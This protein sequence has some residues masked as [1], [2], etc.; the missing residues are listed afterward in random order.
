VTRR[1]D[2]CVV[3]GGL[4]G[5][6]VARALLAA[7]DGLSLLVLEKE[8][9]VGV[10]Q[11]GHNSGVVH[12]GLYYRPGSLKAK[13]CVTGRRELYDL[14]DAATLPVRRSGKVVVATD[15]A[16]LGALDELERRGLANGL[17]G[18]RR[19]DPSGLAELEPNAV[20]VAALHV[21]DTGVIDFPAV[22]I[23]LADLL[24]A[25]GAD[26]RTGHRVT[27]ITHTGDGVAVRAGAE[28]FSARVLVNC[29]GLHSDRIAEL[30]RVQPS[31]RIVP[32]RGEYYYLHPR[33]DD[34]VRNLIYPVPDPRF[35]F[36][37]VHFTRTVGGEVEVGPNAV[38]ALGRQHYHGE[39]PDWRDVRETVTDRGFL[40]LAQRHAR[41][42]AGELLRSRSKR[43]YARRARRL[44]PAVRAE[45]LVGGWAGVRAQAVDRHGALVD[46]F[47]IEQAGSTVH[48]LNAPSPGATA[49]LAIG[50]HIAD[51]LQ[52]PLLR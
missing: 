19:L 30:A 26:L 18:M 14:C 9:R 45:H 2:V 52:A 13:L 20:G 17:V 28:E 6:A 8:E 5:L 35:P 48:V 31:V 29:A 27:A 23:H 37:G 36:L 49:S 1:Y 51:R 24:V 40:R 16:E 44:V 47:V 42:G 39:R 3:G 22:A 10:H 32:F 38:L 41:F 11:T 50:R 21:P 7:Y 12:S 33:A 46:D 25:A 34:L 4:V 15:P 43:L